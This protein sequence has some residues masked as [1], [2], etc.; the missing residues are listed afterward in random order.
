[1]SQKFQY[2]M[3]SFSFGSRNFIRFN[4][5]K[6]HCMPRHGGMHMQP[7][8]ERKEGHRNS[9]PAS[10]FGEFQV[11]LIYRQTLYQEEK[12]NIMIYVYVYAKYNI[13]LI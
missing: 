3:L 13:L 1:M 10:L 6:N 7:M 4:F 2:D 5:N 8:R 12:V 9:R 11:C